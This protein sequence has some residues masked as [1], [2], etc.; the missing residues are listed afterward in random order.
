MARIVEDLE[1]GREE[2]RTRLEFAEALAK[3]H[4]DQIT[5]IVAKLEG[6]RETCEEEN[7]RGRWCKLEILIISGEDAVGWTQWL[8]HYF[9]RGDRR[10]GNAGNNARSKSSKLVSMVQ[11]RINFQVSAF[12]D[13]ESFLSLKQSE[14]VELSRYWYQVRAFP[15]M[16]L[17]LLFLVCHIF[18][19]EISLQFLGPINRILTQKNWIQLAARSSPIFFLASPLLLNPSK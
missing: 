10:G 17:S 3:K 1:Q 9:E 2:M 19:L 8:E 15:S 18:Q 4:E 13:P 16:P 5:D 6:I 12:N 7:R 11:I 14:T